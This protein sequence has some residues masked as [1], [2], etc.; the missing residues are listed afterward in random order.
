MEDNE[1]EIEIKAITRPPQPVLRTWVGLGA[2]Y[3]E[4]LVGTGFS[5]ARDVHE[6][7]KERVKDVLEVVESTQRGVTALVRRLY[8]HLDVVIEDSLKTSEQGM[9]TLV[10]S[11]SSTADDVAQIAA[12]A[13]STWVGNS[14]DRAA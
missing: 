3:G 5:A 13:G 10:R 7:W 9:L 8:G 14:A 4:K 6:E 11:V 12:Q 2:R 1:T